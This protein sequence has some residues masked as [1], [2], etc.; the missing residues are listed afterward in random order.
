[1][2]V[3][4]TS[5]KTR[6]RFKPC[7]PYRTAV[8]FG[9]VLYNLCGY[10]VRFGQW[11]LAVLGRLGFSSTAANLMS[12]TQV[13]PYIILVDSGSLYFGVFAKNSTLHQNT[14]ASNA[15]H[16]GSCLICELECGSRF[17]KINLP[18]AVSPAVLKCL[19]R[20]NINEPCGAQNLKIKFCATGKK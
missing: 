3:L 17:L 19:V 13:D 20:F 7:K 4:S 14:T 2:F 18:F 6:S 8:R 15:V 10:R 12:R 11:T 5:T 16:C 1:M 9:E